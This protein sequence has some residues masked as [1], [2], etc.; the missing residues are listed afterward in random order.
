MLKTVVLLNF[1]ME[2]VICFSGFLNEYIPKEQHLFETESFYNSLYCH[3]FR[4]S[5]LIS[6][7]EPNMN[8]NQNSL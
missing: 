5:C 4:H 8:M 6:F 1:F 7:N 3:N 2:I